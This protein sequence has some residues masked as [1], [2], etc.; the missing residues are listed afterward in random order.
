MGGS[1]KDVPRGDDGGHDGASIAM[2]GD[3]SCVAVS[4]MSD[5]EKRRCCTLCWQCCPRRVPVRVR[6]LI[7]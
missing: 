7:V 1:G 4:S 6:V 3:R 5:T 2:F